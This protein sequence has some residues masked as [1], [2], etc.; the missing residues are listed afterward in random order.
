M[1]P[2]LDETWLIP[3]LPTKGKVFVDVGANVGQWCRYLEN[4]FEKTIA[5]EPNPDSS[6]QIRNSLSKVQLHECA[7]SDGTGEVFLH[8]YKD[9]R[10]ASLHL[11]DTE[12]DKT[13]SECT[14][15]IKVPTRTL[16]S[17]LDGVEE[18]SFIKIDVE[19]HENEVLY[20]ARS[21][22]RIYMPHI[23][24][25]AHSTTCKAST[26]RTLLD[27]DYEVVTV[28]HPRYKM[29]SYEWA[30]HSWVIGYTL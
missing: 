11:R 15:N 10:H 1:T 4:R 17:I 25:E 3:Y 13:C 7:A 5:I 14:G 30:N 26:I 27:F 29:Y 22:L 9:N 19:G 23:I 16:D 8:L 20:G 21:T 12:I 2:H 24:V 28:C 18:I 6:I